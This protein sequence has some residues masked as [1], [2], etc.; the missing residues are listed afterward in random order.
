MNPWEPDGI[1]LMALCGV[2]VCVCVCVCVCVW[3][4]VDFIRSQVLSLNVTDLDR[5]M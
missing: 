2:Y 1:E 5:V 4:S 3:R